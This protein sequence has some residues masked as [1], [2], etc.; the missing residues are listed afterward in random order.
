[1]YKRLAAR[2]FKRCIVKCRMY[3]PEFAV[4]ITLAVMNEIDEAVHIVEY[5]ADWPAVAANELG[6]LL[7]ALAG[8][9]VGIEHIGSTSVPGMAAK[10]V[11]DLMLGVVTYP[12]P[13]RIRLVLESL[14]Y[15]SY[16]E[17]SVPGRLYFVL[18]GARDINLHAVGLGQQHWTNNLALRDYLRRNPEARAQYAEAKR[19]AIGDGAR[20]LLS[21]SAAKADTVAALVHAARSA[22]DG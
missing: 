10:P 2:W 5:Q 12:P 8:M 14:G 3:R 18:R 22:N 11:I 7:P 19:K 21:Y 13:E 17:G 20:T 16:G 6:R 1:M 9:H 15:I 4:Y